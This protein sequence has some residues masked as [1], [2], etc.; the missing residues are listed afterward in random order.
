MKITADMKMFDILHEHEKAI[1]VFEAFGLKCIFCH[2]NHT[3]TLE[4]ACILN[5]I[6]VEKILEELNKLERVDPIVDMV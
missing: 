4:K 3:D 1:D 6:K 2:G 5:N